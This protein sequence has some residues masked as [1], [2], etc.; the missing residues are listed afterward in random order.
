MASTHT[1]SKRASASKRAAWKGKA[2]NDGAS[3]GQWKGACEENPDAKIGFAVVSVKLRPAEKTEFQALCKELGV[4]PNWAMR[5]M[6]RQAS[7]FLEV[8]KSALNELRVITRQIS[9][10][11]TNINQIAKAGNRT[12]SPDYRAFMEDRKELGK[13]L[14]RLER[15]MQ[16]VLHVGQRR[17]DGLAKLKSTLEGS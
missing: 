17:A 8:D 5:S 10:V 7:G 13:H 15:M 3:R 16:Q 11:A 4:S 6:V 1:K 12:L 14:A 2:P 9:G